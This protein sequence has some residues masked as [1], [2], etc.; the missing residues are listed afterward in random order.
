MCIRDS[1][2]GLYKT[3]AHVAGFYDPSGD[4]AGVYF[5]RACGA[6]TFST[7]GRRL[8]AKGAALFCLIAIFCAA[9][10][11]LSLAAFQ[12]VVAGHAERIGHGLRLH[13]DLLQADGQILDHLHIV[14]SLIHI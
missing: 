9:G 13:A 2:S 12:P 14:L 10:R 5:I 3:H 11:C 6:K 7:S 8:P 4:A 1:D